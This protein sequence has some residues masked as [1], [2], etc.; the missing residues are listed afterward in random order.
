MI[1]VIIPVF[2]GGQTLNSCL[3]SVFASDYSHFEVI[4][5][6]DHS[7]DNS[8]TV[9]RHWPCRLIELPS[10]GGAAAARNAGAAVSAGSILFFLDADI[11]IRPESLSRVAAVFRENANVA[12]LF[13]S[14]GEDT[15]PKDF[16]SQYKNLLHHYTHQNSRT[17][18]TTFASGFGG[19]RAK[20]FDE[21]NG[22]QASQRFLEDIEFGYRMRER[23]YRV[24]LDKGLQMTHCKR[25]TFTSLVRSDFFGRAIPWTMLMLE[26]RTYQ[27]DMNTRVNNLLSFPVSALLL[28][29]PVLFPLRQIGI[30]SLSLIS[31]LIMLNYGFLSFLYAKRGARFALGGVAMIWFFY[32]YSGLGALVACLSYARLRFVENVVA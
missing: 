19:V 22:F 15:I 16:F 32:L 29:A 7:T 2:N 5:V 17:D 30:V 14:F 12:A 26:R 11:L 18:A 25:Y 8:R 23:G 20:V 13:G 31:L 21:L 24:L 4:V 9:A 3:S 27:N 6:D 10:N 1:S 28:V